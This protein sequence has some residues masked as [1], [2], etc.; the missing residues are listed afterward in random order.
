MEQKEK[1]IAVAEHIEHQQYM[2]EGIFASDIKEYQRNFAAKEE[3]RKQALESL[4][5]SKEQGLEE[6]RKSI[7][8]EVKEPAL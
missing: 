8:G 1:I 6:D 7:A 2:W 3:T 4:L 5:E